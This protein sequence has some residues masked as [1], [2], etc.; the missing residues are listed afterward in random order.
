MSSQTQKKDLFYLHVIVYFLLTFAI[1]LLP[2]IGVTSYGMKIIGVFLG[3]IYGWTFLGFVWPSLF[4]MVALGFTGYDT[5]PNII[6]AGIGHPTVLFTIFVCIFVGV[7]Q[8]LW[9]K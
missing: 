7:L 6:A 2:P 5:P 8:G 1:G 9:F 3:L 4:S